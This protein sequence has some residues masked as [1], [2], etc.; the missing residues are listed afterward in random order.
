MPP[1]R[2]AVPFAA[3]LVPEKPTVA[4]TVRVVLMVAA[5]AAAQ[6]NRPGT[7]VD[8]LRIICLF[9]SSTLSFNT[10]EI[11]GNPAQQ[12]GP[13]AGFGANSI[14]KLISGAGIRQTVWGAYL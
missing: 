2:V 11:P 4:F 14:S 8:N 7:K 9:E 6:S 10:L 13:P 1:V 5:D 12:P 3:T